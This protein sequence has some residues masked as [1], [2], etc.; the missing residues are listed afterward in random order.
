MTFELSEGFDQNR[1]IFLSQEATKLIAGTER[2]TTNSNS[3]PST[4]Q[5]A[6]ETQ[7]SSNTRFMC[8]PST[9]TGISNT[10]RVLGNFRNRFVPYGSSS[11]R[12]LPKGFLNATI[13]LDQRPS[14]AIRSVYDAN[15][16]REDYLTMDEGLL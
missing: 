4:Q 8:M 2:L 5:T 16:L 9:S 13:D 11:C 1:A 14:I 10:N 3:G 6:Q 15:V 12:K 7:S